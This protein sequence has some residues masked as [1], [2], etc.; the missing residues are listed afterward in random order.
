MTNTVTFRYPSKAFSYGFAEQQVE[1]PLELSPTEIAKMYVAAV[2]EYQEA[3]IAANK[4]SRTDA[5]KATEEMMAR[6]L[7][8]TK[9][10]EEPNKESEVKALWEKPAEPAAAKPWETQAP[11]VS[12][13]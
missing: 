1:V 9:I 4:E 5:E 11:K 8:A 12:L 10:S 2:R 3:E 6:E 13:F 7:G